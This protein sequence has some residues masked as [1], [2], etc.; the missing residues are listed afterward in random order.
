[1]VSEASEPSTL[2]QFDY[3]VVPLSCGVIRTIHASMSKSLFLTAI[4]APCPL[5][6]TFG[7]IRKR[8][9]PVV[10]A[11]YPRGMDSWHLR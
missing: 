10:V 5:P 8:T 1:M 2:F 7:L 6:V 4:P 11:L 9:P 3:P